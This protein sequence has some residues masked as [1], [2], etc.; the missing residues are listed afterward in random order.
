MGVK[1]K[2]DTPTADSNFAAIRTNRTLI[3]IPDNPQATIDHPQ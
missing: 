3:N 2:Q 1:V